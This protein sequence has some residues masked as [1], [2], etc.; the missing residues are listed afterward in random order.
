MKKRELGMPNY[1]D[2]KSSVFLN[3]AGKSILEFS[4]VSTE[5]RTSKSINTALASNAAFLMRQLPK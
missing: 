2:E 1:I 3:F 5:L 4:V